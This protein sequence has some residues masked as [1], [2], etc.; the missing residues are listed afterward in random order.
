MLGLGTA[1]STVLRLGRSDADRATGRAELCG[2]QARSAVG[3]DPLDLNVLQRTLDAVAEPLADAV[4]VTG[5]LE[6]VEVDLPGGAC[7]GVLLD[8]RLPL[9]EERQLRVGLQALDTDLPPPEL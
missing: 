9:D 2:D 1:P 6:S 7:A 5:D 8:R 4:R 3:G